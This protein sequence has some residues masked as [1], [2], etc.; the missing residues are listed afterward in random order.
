LY[1]SYIK[2]DPGANENENNDLPGR[3]PLPG[4]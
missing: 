1:F 3:V 2:S 4:D